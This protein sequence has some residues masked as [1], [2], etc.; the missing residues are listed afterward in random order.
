MQ[1]AQF[2]GHPPD[3][4]LRGPNNQRGKNEWNVDEEETPPNRTD[5]VIAKLLGA[6]CWFWIL[7]S[8]KRDNG[9]AFVSLWY[10]SI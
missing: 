10:Y 3:I 9:K 2:G 5:E 4:K 8:I 1:T 6:M 7:Y